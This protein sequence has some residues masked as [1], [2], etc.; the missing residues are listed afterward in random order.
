MSL[1]KKIYGGF[2]ILLG[3]LLMFAFYSISQL[4][5][6]TKDYEQLLDDPVKQTQTADNVQKQMALQGLYIR[7]YIG[8][9]N[10]ESLESLREHQ[11]TLKEEVEKLS[12]LSKS[13]KM[14]TLIQEVNEG[15]V[16][17]DT[18]AEKI[19]QF[20]RSEDIEGAEKLMANEGREANL[21]ILAAGEE[22]EAYQL[23]QLNESRLAIQKKVAKSKRSLI[24]SVFSDTILA[25]LI[26]TVIHRIVSRPIHRLSAASTVIASGD[27]T[28]EDVHVK[29]KDEIWELANSFNMMKHNLRTVIS[30][31]HDNALHVTAS[32]EQLSASTQEVTLASQS[33][34][35]N[36]EVVAT[37]ATVSAAT[38]KDSS[39][40]ME[41]TAIGVQR[42]AESAQNLNISVEETEKLAEESE[43]SVQNAKNQMNIIYD[44]SHET[45]ELIQRLS[46]QTVEIE[47]ITKVITEITEQ[48]NLLAL[49]AAIEAARA[50]EQG[51]GFAVVADEVRNLAEQSKTS[52]NQIVQL[53]AE[54][55]SDTQN[56]EQSVATSLKNVEEGVHAIEEAGIAFSTIA[57]AINKMGD[58]I[59]EISSATEEI[60]ASAEEVSASV[61]EIATHADEASAKSEDNSA[62]VEE[63]MATIEEINT[64]AIDLSNQA[65]RLQQIIQEFKI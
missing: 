1:G 54:I 53:T 62:A 36:M 19:I 61:Q 51:K 14:K 31:I 24:I 49:N 33:V 37:G 26:A 38:A 7:A 21:A 35:T 5:S 64:V 18:T 50:G 58:Q 22:M 63:Q 28:Q 8:N 34:A 9:Q 20:V 16:F 27:L 23:Q 6:V 29:S 42:I 39:I 32:A 47:N 3:V 55:Q 4:T 56:V 65:L 40:A 60:S 45:S 13:E 25:L 15:I 59:E 30:S 41:E 46:K 10:D 12:V 17:F 48:T 52:A 57:T 11:H 2:G 43:Q 44:S